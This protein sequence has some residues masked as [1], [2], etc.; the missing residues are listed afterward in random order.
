MRMQ[1]LAPANHFIVITRYFVQCRHR[2]VS[3]SRELM[4]TRGLATAKKYH[5]PAEL[6]RF[7]LPKAIS[8]QTR[9][10]VHIK[11]NSAQSGVSLAG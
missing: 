8:A 5:E 2:K 6:L 7:P 4:A 1:I 10:F 9:S 3:R 11:S